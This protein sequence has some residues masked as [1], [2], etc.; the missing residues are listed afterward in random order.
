MAVDKLHV[1][2]GSARQLV[3]L[4]G[5][6]KFRN[7]LELLVR[8]YGECVRTKLAMEVIRLVDF[9]LLMMVAQLLQKNKYLIV[10]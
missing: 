5:L 2:L 7:F 8:Q 6:L 1:R 3:A 9:G 10:V 4:L